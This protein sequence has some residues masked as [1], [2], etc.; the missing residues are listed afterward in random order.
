MLGRKFLLQPLAMEFFSSSGA[1]QFL[2]FSFNERD[3]VLRRLTAIINALKPSS[4]I[5]KVPTPVGLDLPLIDERRRASI[6]G[7]DIVRLQM[8]RCTNN[9]MQQEIKLGAQ[10]LRPQQVE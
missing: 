6:D 7:N 2:I 9:S 8:R 10:W 1:T 5:K 4:E 3:T